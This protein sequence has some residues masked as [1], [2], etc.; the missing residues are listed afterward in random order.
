MPKGVCVCVGG[1]RMKYRQRDNIKHLFSIRWL[2]ESVRSEVMDAHWV[3]HTPIGIYCKLHLYQCNTG[4]CCCMSLFLFS[5]STCR[6]TDKQTHRATNRERQNKK[7]IARK[8]TLA[9]R[10]SKICC[11]FTRITNT[12]CHTCQCE[13]F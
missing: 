7:T 6:Q 2:G 8:Q 1:I 10:H 12:H 3:N 5:Q 9:T 13:L 11:T 4:R